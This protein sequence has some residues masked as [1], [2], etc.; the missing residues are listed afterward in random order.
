MKPGGI[1]QKAGPV[2][3]T[4]LMDSKSPSDN[5]A[6]SLNLSIQSAQFQNRSH[7]DNFRNTIWCSYMDIRERTPTVAAEVSS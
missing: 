2:G 1:G 4:R 6:S 7:L 5:S 3:N